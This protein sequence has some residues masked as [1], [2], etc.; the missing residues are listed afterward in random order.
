MKMGFKMEYEDVDLIHVA[1]CGEGQLAG[2][3]LCTR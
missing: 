1:G 3:L 2:G